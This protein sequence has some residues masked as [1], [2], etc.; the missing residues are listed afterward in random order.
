M[1]E[2]LYIFDFDDTLFDVPSSEEGKIIWK[3]KTNREWNYKGSWWSEEIT[4]DTNIFP[5]IRN[6]WMYKEY[7]KVTKEPNSIRVLVTGRLN[8][9]P[10]MRNRVVSL[11]NENNFSFDEVFKMNT[12]PINGEGGIYLS[13]G[14]NTF[15]FKSKLFEK[16]IKKTNCKELIMYDDRTK[17][18]LMFEDWAK[19]QNCSVTIVNSITHKIIEIDNVS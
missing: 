3:N 12:Y 4:L 8:F 9:I 14:G 16:L 13:T 1:V 7:L 6:D 17:H 19:N 5:I 18:L 2:K 10:N 11:L 15:T